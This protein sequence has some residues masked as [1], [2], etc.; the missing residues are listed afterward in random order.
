MLFDRSPLVTYSW[1]YL[2]T[3]TNFPAPP[4]ACSAGGQSCVILS[5]LPQ[6]S[7]S[8]QAEKEGRAFETTASN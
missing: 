4:Q 2:Q 5:T 8:T 7:A 6:K 3:L 1:P